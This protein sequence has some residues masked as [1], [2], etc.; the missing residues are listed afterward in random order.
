MALPLALTRNLPVGSNVDAAGARGARPAKT[1]QP[2]RRTGYVTAG[3]GMAM[4]AELLT[5]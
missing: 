1:W 4:R 3:S 5:P 2:V